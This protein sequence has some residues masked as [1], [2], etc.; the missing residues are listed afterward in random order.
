VLPVAVDC[1]GV[2]A[3]FDCLSYLSDSKCSGTG[4]GAT[5]GSTLSY[6][7]YKKKIRDAIYIFWHKSSVLST[8]QVA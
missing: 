1:Q 8:F 4:C 2:A 7:C 3:L 6:H 5:E